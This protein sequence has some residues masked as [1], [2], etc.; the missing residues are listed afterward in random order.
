MMI[1]VSQMY[2]RLCAAAL[3]RLASQQIQVGMPMQ[4]SRGDAARQ[5]RDVLEFLQM[6]AGEDLP[7]LINSSAQLL[8]AIADGFERADNNS[9]AQF[10][11]G[12]P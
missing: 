7:M 11:E 8:S 6:I 4:E 1:Q 10:F 5:E 2:L 12:S 9:A 3:R